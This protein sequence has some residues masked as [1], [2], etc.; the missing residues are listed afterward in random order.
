MDSR[1]VGNSEAKNLISSLEEELRVITEDQKDFEID[2][3]FVQN[4]VNVDNEEVL[5]TIYSPCIQ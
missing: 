3:P 4:L 2:G 5:P 1:N